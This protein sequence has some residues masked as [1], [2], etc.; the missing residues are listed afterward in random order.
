MF[1][2][3]NLL[4]VFITFT[5]NYF[6]YLY[7][8]PFKNYVSGAPY[9]F[10]IFKDLVWLSFALFILLY[11]L[12]NARAPIKAPVTLIAF[13]FVFLAT[14]I[15]HAV[16]L[17]LGNLL[18]QGLKN[19]L[20][21]LVLFLYFFTF[22]DEVKRWLAD[23]FLKVIVYSVVIQAAFAVFQLV[24]F[25]RFSLM[26]DGALVG[27]VGI[28][29]SF[30]FLINTAMLILYIG[31]CFEPDWKKKAG[32]LAL[33]CFLFVC[34]VL[35][36]SASQVILAVVILA[37]VNIIYFR[38]RPR[39]L[40]RILV[41]LAVVSA[42]VAAFG[43]HKIIIEETPIARVFHQGF[44]SYSIDV[45]VQIHSF[46]W[47]LLT[48][49]SLPTVLFGSFE[50]E[51]YLSMDSTY[52]TLTANH[53]LAGFV[54]FLILLATYYLISLR[55]FQV[56]RKKNVLIYHCMLLLFSMMFVFHI[57]LYYYVL[58]GV[59]FLTL[60]ALTYYADEAGWGSGGGRQRWQTVA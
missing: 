5:L 45:R 31:S 6:I 24:V 39:T 30:G 25:P 48:Q 41:L 32:M 15:L 4:L 37:Y 50:S 26:E 2:R 19:A 16:H 49:G 22:S 29:H 46:L 17:N 53:G 58:N 27:F 43:L 44:R 52:V 12:A 36:K 42:V 10:V 35:T 55:T 54:A 13:V 47:N 40:L 59:F 1:T 21:E 51:Q 14:S 9:I 11:F 60:A 28:P 23:S 7:F 57:S 8:F 18:H 20:M 56:S 38:I 33:Y 34:V 3:P